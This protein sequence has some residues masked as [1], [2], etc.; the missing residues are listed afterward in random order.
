M[1]RLDEIN[2]TDLGVNWVYCTQHVG[3]HET[4]WCSVDKSQ[5]TPLKANT[6]TEATEEVKAK[7]WP[8]SGYCRVCYEFIA[9][10]GRYTHCAKHD[11]VRN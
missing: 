6:R 2:D 3:P 11:R 1:E 7:G 10:Q 9:N 4:G 5:K 8:I